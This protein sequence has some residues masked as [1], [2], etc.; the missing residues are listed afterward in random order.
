MAP[1]PLPGPAVLVAVC[2]AGR[3]GKDAV[4]ARFS[5][6]GYAH[7]KFAAPLKRAV[8]ELFGLPACDLETEAKDAPS[9]RCGGATPREVLQWLGTEVLQRQLPRQLAPDLGRELLARRLWQRACDGPA[10]RG[11]VVSDLRFVHEHAYVRERAQRL[12]V[13]RVERPAGARMGVG[14]P[15]GA[16]E[17]EL[18]HARIPADFV[19]YNDASLEDLLVAADAVAGAVGCG[20]GGGAREPGEPG[21]WM[22]AAT[23]A[24]AAAAAAAAARV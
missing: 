15:A 1:A 9:E 23:T 6:L 13:V 5:R 7:L 3:A 17:S 21:R 24:M 12:V 20:V 2:G 11:V 8:A 19:I 10:C 14:G 16:H 4:A 18:D 22:S